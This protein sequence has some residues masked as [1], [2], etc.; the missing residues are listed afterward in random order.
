MF[1]WFGLSSYSCCFCSRSL[2]TRS[3]AEIFCRI[4]KKKSTFH[5]LFIFMLPLCKTSVLSCLEL[6]KEPGRKV[7]ASVRDLF[8]K[9]SALL[10]RS[11]MAGPL[12]SR[13][14]PESSA[15]ALPS[16]NWNSRLTWT[17]RRLCSREWHPGSS[18][19]T[20]IPSR[21]VHTW[22]NL[23]PARTR[24]L[25]PSLKP[26]WRKSLSLFSL[27][28]FALITFRLCSLVI[29][30]FW[31]PCSFRLAETEFHRIV[32]YSCSARSTFF[33]C[34]FCLFCVLLCGSRLPHKRPPA[35]FFPVYQISWIV[36][37]FFL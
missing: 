34:C 13:L 22:W 20:R 11:T 18:G 8:L 23:W 31:D 19:I 37:L 17:D 36:I 1:A 16:P 28:H 24:T 26:L 4:D 5:V 29:F 3:H 9:I 25:Q 6:Q 2:L 30:E 10:E 33:C 14:G 15:R 12:W 21:L 32:P 35:I 7:S 27:F